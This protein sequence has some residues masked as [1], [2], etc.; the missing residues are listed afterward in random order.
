MEMINRYKDRS[1]VIRPL[2]ESSFRLFLALDNIGIHVL[3]K[4]YYTPVPDRRW[5][6]RHRSAWMGR[7]PLQIPGWDLD[8][9]LAW[10]ET[11]CSPYY[12]EVKGLDVFESLKEY[13]EGFGAIESQVLHCFIRAMKPRRIV[14]IGSGVSTAC[15]LHAVSM[16][17]GTKFGTEI[18]CIE[19]YPKPAFRRL[20]PITHI[21]ELC[22]SVPE[23][24]FTTLDRGDLLFIDSTHSVKTGSDVVHL[25]LKVVPLLRPG[26][27][28]HIHDMNL[29]YAYFR[30]ELENY[31]GWQE[32]ALV[33]AWLTH[34]PKL[35]VL[36]SLSA[37]QYDRPNELKSILTDYQPQ[38]N[39]EG[40]R[41]SPSAPGHFPSSL[42]LQSA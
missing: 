12:Q 22:Q 20:S 14:E 36:A 27:F 1:S 38:A 39:V 33:I 42:W 6:L 21:Q 8:K 17:G 30:D 7:V 28:I 25:Y 24:V 16:N 10:L 2:K 5:L 35:Q 4:H 31:F 13:G 15:M 40:L 19:P 37:L 41:P 11:T 9:H 18:T 26:V 32:T 34:N 23:S 3:P 29:P